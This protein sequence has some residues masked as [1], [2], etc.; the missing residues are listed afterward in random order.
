MKTTIYELLGMV[1]DNKTPKR[2]LFRS[3]VYKYEEEA[4]DYYNVEY[5]YIFDEWDIV[6]IL[7]EP[8]EILETIITYKQEDKILEENIMLKDENI[9]LRNELYELKNNKPDKIEKIPIKD[10]KIQATSTNN[11]CYSI[12]QPMKIII[13]KINEIIDRLNNL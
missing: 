6:S 5:G 1:K 4:K 9:E 10:M 11:Y 13:N 8:V 3:Q 2:I 12:S 7:N